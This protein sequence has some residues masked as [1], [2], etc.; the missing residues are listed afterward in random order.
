MSFQDGTA[1]G[2]TQYSSEQLRVIA[3][4]INDG[5]KAGQPVSAVQ[6]AQ[7]VKK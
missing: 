3:K 1:Y 7:S 6:A 4:T 5:L 2:V